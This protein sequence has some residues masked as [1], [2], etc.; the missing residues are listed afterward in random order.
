M[1][2]CLGGRDISATILT[3]HVL[4]HQ[5]VPA[6]EMPESCFVET[7]NRSC[8]CRIIKV[9]FGEGEMK[10]HLMFI[11]SCEV[12]NNCFISMWLFFSKV[13]FRNE[14]WVVYLKHHVLD[15]S[16]MWLVKALFPFRLSLNAMTSSAQTFWWKFF[17]HTSSQHKSSD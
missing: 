9:H 10:T 1:L 15:L 16:M 4:L 17:L 3:L 2:L 11:R 8:N 5:F 12:E 7:Q 13:I 6:I 14:R